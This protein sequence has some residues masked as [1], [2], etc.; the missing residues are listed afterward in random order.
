MI[1]LSF[2]VCSP[3]ILG[4]YDDWTIK[5]SKNSPLVHDM[6]KCMHQDHSNDIW[7]GTVKGLNVA[8]DDNWDLYTKSTGLPHNYIVD[9]TEDDKGIV[10][11]ATYKGLA[12]FEDQKWSYIRKGEGLVNNKIY[13]LEKDSKGN[14]WV[15][16][17]K[18]VSVFDGQ[19]WKTYAGESGLAHIH[20]LDIMEDMNGNMWFA[21]RK[22]ISFYDGKSWQSFNTK[23]GLA[24]NFVWSIAEDSQGNIWSGTHTGAFSKFDGSNWETIH[25]GSV[26]YDFT[27]IAP[28][29]INGVAWTLLFGAPVG[30]AVMAGL[31]AMGF[32]PS[33]NHV[34]LVYFDAENNAWLVAQ[35]KGIFLFDGNDWTHL[36]TENGLPDHRVHDILETREGDIWL[37]TSRG[38]AIMNK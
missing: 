24:R 4:Q 32:L 37:G 36:T 18:G 31:A 20:V 27:I 35:P 11:I 34:T 2:S 38:I 12:L 28:E 10:W 8:G 26:Y 17:R 33:A 6:V 19:A 7:I 1:I 15:G 29:V 21:T 22:G 9:I 5:N 3:V 25:K 30:S 13:T 23:D 14:M 16:T